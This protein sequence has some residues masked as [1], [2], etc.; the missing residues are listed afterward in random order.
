MGW[1]AMKIA[2]VSDDERTISRHF[3]RAEKY[4]V[5]SIDQAAVTAKKSFPKLD[6][7][8]SSHRRHGR[9]GQLEHAGGSGLGKQSR[10]N[11]EQLFANIRDCDVLVSGGMGRG[12]YLDLQ[13]LGI[14]PIVTDMTDIDAAV[15]AVVDDT[16]VDHVDKLH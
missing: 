16:I 2:I 12:A 11:H 1:K 10:L 13:S 3:G 15:Q 8:H 6:F 9:H 14:R 4:V 5:V 7:C